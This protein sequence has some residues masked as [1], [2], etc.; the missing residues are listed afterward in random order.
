MCKPL[1]AGY[2]Q[3]L[4]QGLV[5]QGMAC[6]LLLMMSSGGVD[7]IGK[8]LSLIRSAWSNPGP[9]AVPFL[10]RSVAAECGLSDV[11]SFDMGGTTAKICLIDDFQPQLSRSFEVARM[12]RFLKGS[13]LPIPKFQQSIW[14]KSAPVAALSHA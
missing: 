7:D 14:S 11:L 10:S 3:R 1:I 6:P 4:K 8:P 2:L 5:K 12:Y 13:G 9:Q